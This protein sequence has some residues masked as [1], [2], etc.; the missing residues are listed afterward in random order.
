MASSHCQLI[1]FSGSGGSE[2]GFVEMLTSK[3]LEIGPVYKKM[4]NRCHQHRTAPSHDTLHQ[5]LVLSTNPVS[6]CTMRA[7]YIVEVKIPRNTLHTNQTL[8]PPKVRDGCRLPGNL[9][10]V[11]YYGVK[12]R[13]D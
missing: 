4:T 8:H 5:I 13:S 12:C 9:Q 11:I 1:H 7:T 2:N 10:T 6:S 3:R